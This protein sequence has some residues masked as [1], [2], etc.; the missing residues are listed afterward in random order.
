MHQRGLD[1]A[2][3][4]L[5]RPPRSLRLECGS[6][7]LARPSQILREV[8]GWTA[9][10]VSALRWLAPVQDHT[11]EVSDPR[12]P[13]YWHELRLPPRCA[14]ASVLLTPASSVHSHQPPALV[15][16]PDETT[17]GQCA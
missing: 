3:G 11:A 12:H 5:R 2:L 14:R 8:P 7:A 10:P 15:A 13:G 9:Q 17:C 6:V 1:R 4:A 16:A